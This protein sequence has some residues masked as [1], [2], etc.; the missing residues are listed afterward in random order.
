MSKDIWSNLK[1]VEPDLEPP[2]K[3][4]NHISDGLDQATGGKINFEIEKVNYFPEEVSYGQP[5]GL[6]FESR[7]NPHPPFGYDTSEGTDL[8][9]R[10]RY[11]LYVTDEPSIKAEIFKFRYPL[12]FYP[13]RFFIRKGNFSSLDTFFDDDDIL[14]GEN[15][16]KFFEICQKIFSSNEFNRI[17]KR[18]AALGT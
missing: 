18:L 7:K 4:L 11:L 10:F 6:A 14:R 2:N 15:E 3:I 9:F 12:E 1:N 16:S 8:N 5:F 17:I 13:V